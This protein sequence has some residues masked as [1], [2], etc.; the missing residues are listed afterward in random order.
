MPY[1]F[2]KYRPHFFYRLTAV[3][4]KNEFSIDEIK[5]LLRRDL[6]NLLNTRQSLIYFFPLSTSLDQSAVNY[7]LPDITRINLDSNKDKKLVTK[8]IENQIEKYI[9]SLKEVRVKLIDRKIDPSAD[10]LELHI[11]SVLKISRLNEAMSYSAV[12]DPVTKNLRVSEV[13]DEE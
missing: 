1:V 11:D 3:G 6:E 2:E 9:P 10:T 5:N 13:F 8:N 12:I 4:N 7:G